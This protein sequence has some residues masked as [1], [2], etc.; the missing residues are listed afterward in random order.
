[1]H[2]GEVNRFLEV[3]GVRMYSLILRVHNEDEVGKA[4][5]REKREKCERFKS[6]TEYIRWLHTRGIGGFDPLGDAQHYHIISI[7]VRFDIC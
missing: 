5:G 7:L 3:V 6:T 2:H 1:M 4:T